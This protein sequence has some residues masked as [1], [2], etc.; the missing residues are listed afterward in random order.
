MLKSM[1]LFALALTCATEVHAAA[2]NGLTA[3]DS[4]SAQLQRKFEADD[5]KRPRGNEMKLSQTSHQD[6]GAL[7]LARIVKGVPWAIKGRQLTMGAGSHRRTIARLDQKLGQIL[8]FDVDIAS[9]SPYVLTDA[10]IV[11]VS[12][13][14]SSP[15]ILPLPAAQLGLTKIKF[16]G[17]DLYAVDRLSRVRRL[18]ENPKDTDVVANAWGKVRDFAVTDHVAVVLTGDAGQVGTRIELFELGAPGATTAHRPAFQSIDTEFPGRAVDLDGDTILVGTDHG[19]LAYGLATAHDEDGGH[20]VLR[21]RPLAL[22]EM[23]RAD[24]R[25]IVRRDSMVLTVESEV[26]TSDRHK[27]RAAALSDLDDEERATKATTLRR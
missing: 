10:H 19:V 26:G 1:T 11:R 5:S 23:G 16:V 9:G 27:F 14:G 24:V 13:D 20:A 21:R 22:G 4:V 8:D 15:Q 2:C 25:A 18:L 7:D 6:M 17:H 12:L 3:S